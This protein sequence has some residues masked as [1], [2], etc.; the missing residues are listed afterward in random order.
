MLKVITT[1]AEVTTVNDYTVDELPTRCTSCFNEMTDGH[2][3]KCH[4]LLT[5]DEMDAIDTEFAF[6]PKAAVRSELS[7]KVT[8]RRSGIYRKA[9]R[10][11]RGRRRFFTRKTR[12]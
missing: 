1:E 8:D 2:C 3:F 11:K 6:L 12:S 10:G 4:P 7:Y 5:E 9:V